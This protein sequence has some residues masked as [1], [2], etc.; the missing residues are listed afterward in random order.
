MESVETVW[1][2][3]V[4]HLDTSSMRWALIW[5]DSL[6]QDGSKPQRAV[7]LGLDVG[8]GMLSSVILHLLWGLGDQAFL[9]NLGT[10][11]FYWQRYGEYMLSLTN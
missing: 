7:V 6:T 9:C 5:L 3:H 2:V 1:R 11:Q 8:V 10:M 4:S